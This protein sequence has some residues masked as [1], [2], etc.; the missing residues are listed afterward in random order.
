MKRLAQ[1][2]KVRAIDFMKNNSYT[3]GM[4]GGSSVNLLIDKE[5]LDRKMKE[6]GFRSYYEL[7]DDAKRRGINLLVRTIYNI[8]NGGNYSQD[9]LAALCA[10]LRCVPA[11]LVPGWNGGKSPNTQVTPQLEQEPQGQPA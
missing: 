11:D 1:N 4:K 9:K 7:S 5:C 6:A 8:A 10:A 2:F 3:R